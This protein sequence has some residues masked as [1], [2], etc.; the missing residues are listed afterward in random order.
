MR[1]CLLCLSNIDIL[2]NRRKKLKSLF[3]DYVLLKILQKD[4]VDAPYIH[5]SLDS[6]SNY[7]KHF[8]L[9]CF[10]VVVFFFLVIIQKISLMSKDA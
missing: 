4:D 9:S 8:N 7:W 5:R 3:E 10:V 1:S 2:L 6:V